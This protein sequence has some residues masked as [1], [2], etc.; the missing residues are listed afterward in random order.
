MSIRLALAFSNACYQVNKEATKARLQSNLVSIKEL[1]SSRKKIFCEQSNW[2]CNC[3]MCFIGEVRLFSVNL[4]LLA[5]STNH[6]SGN[7]AYKR[8]TIKLVKKCCKISKILRK[9]KTEKA[10]QWSAY[11]IQAEVALCLFD[12]EWLSL[13]I[14]FCMHQS[15]I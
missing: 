15:M 1:E 7:L 10:C 5:M 13:G 11:C 4:E 2:R 3:T 8:K 12:V 9:G 14:S 6:L